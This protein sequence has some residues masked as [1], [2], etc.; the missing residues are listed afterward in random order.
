MSGARL[1]LGATLLLVVV[2]LA[3]CGG[4]DEGERRPSGEGGSASRPPAARFPEPGGR[5][6]AE[7]RQSLGPGP[8]LAPSV[9]LFEPGRNRFGF[10]LFDRSRRQI[11]EARVA[12]Y[13]A[14]TGGGRAEG[15]FPASYESLAVEPEFSS[16]SVTA[17]PDSAQSVYV[18][19]VP[20]RRA[21]EYEVLAVTQLDDRLVAAEPAAVR[22]VEDSPVPSVGD[23][24]IRISTPTVESV[25]GAVQQIDTRVPPSTMHERDFADVLGRRPAILLFATPALCQSRVCGPVVDIAEQV[26]AERGDEAE[27]IHMEIYND[28]EVERGLRPQVTAWHLQSEPWLFAIDRRGRI[29]ARIEGAFSARELEEAVD[30][31]TRG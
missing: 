28:N 5:S 21:G 31:A 19:Q 9:Q 20:F 8:V 2:A 7:L 23:P 16:E 13:T 4:D 25:G 27:F 24:A 6:L 30:L 17:D 3:S 29:A 1:R 10:G 15:P 11:P 26:K 12:L 18:A 14:P 22:V